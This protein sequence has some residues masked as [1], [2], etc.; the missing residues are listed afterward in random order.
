MRRPILPEATR[1]LV[2]QR[3]RHPPTALCVFLGLGDEPLDLADVGGY[4]RGVEI[5]HLEGSGSTRAEIVESDAHDRE[6]MHSVPGVQIDLL[7]T[8]IT[9]VSVDA[10]VNA[11]NNSLLGGGG[12]DGAIHRAG[13]PAI[14]EECRQIGGCS[15]GDAVATTA[16]LLPARHVIHTVGP[17]WSQHPPDE[18]DR[19]L[20][21]CYVRSLEEADRLGCRS[22]AFP[23][24]STGVYGFPKDR[25]AEVAVAAVRSFEPASSVSSVTFVVFDAENER[26]YQDLLTR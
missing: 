1:R 19:L 14:L 5:C 6:G 12:V 2:G 22:V 13:G 7:R 4:R 11:A 20:A 24:I 9:T 8:D 23:N 10:I 18:A 25:A 15:T 16:G 3:Q 17:V 21:S 26:L